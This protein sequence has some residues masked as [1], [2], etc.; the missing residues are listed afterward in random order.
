MAKTVM[1]SDDNK[2]YY[3]GVDNNESKVD[4]GN[5]KSNLVE[6]GE[7]YKIDNG[8][9]Y[10]NILDITGWYFGSNITPVI[11][12]GESPITKEEYINSNTW[13]VTSSTDKNKELRKFTY[14]PTHTYQVILSSTT[15]WKNQPN[16]NDKLKL[17]DNVD[18]EEESYDP[19]VSTGL[20][21]GDILSMR[22]AN[23]ID[24]CF[25]VVS[26]D[27]NRLT[28]KILIDKLPTLFPNPDGSNTSLKYKL[29][30]GNL[31]ACDL[32]KYPNSNT[33]IYEYTFKC[34][35]KPDIG[36]VKLSLTAA[37]IAGKGCEA[38]GEGSLVSG[39]QNKALGDFCCVLGRQNTGVYG[40]FIAGLQN[41]NTS[42]EYAFMFGQGLKPDNSCQHIVGQYNHPIEDA[43]TYRV[44]FVVGKGNNSTNNTSNA[45]VCQKN[46]NVSINPFYVS[47]PE[48]TTGGITFVNDD[49]TQTDALAFMVGYQIPNK[50]YV[51]DTGTKNY[52]DV[53]KIR[54]A[55]DMRGSIIVPIYD[56]KESPELNKPTKKRARMVLVDQGDGS[57]AWEV[58]DVLDPDSETYSYSF[59]E[60]SGKVLKISKT[61]LTT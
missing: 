10:E 25:E 55:V 37:I 56:R 38:L 21:V 31:Y 54:F 3:P 30:S 40:N 13:Q 2:I 5:I 12:E 49:T 8:T 50:K 24:N 22:N 52:T 1:I 27:G 9:T 61:P 57:Y 48:S 34:P 28:Y 32:I 60:G 4:V 41:E 51:N 53:E 18:S 14:S 16:T 26:I 33:D 11:N 44:Y 29:G 20:S 35:S 15:E 36:K 19:N 46:R 47:L 23:N 45:L 6:I 58:I 43:S 42:K 7:D 59:T 39:R 17:Y